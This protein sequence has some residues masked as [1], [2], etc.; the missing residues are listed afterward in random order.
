MFSTQSALKN[1][2]AAK[3]NFKDFRFDIMIENMPIAVM[4]CNI[5]TFEIEYVNEKSNELLETIKHVIDLDPK[6]IVGTSVDVF[7]RDPS[8]QRKLLSDPK[9]LPHQAQITV[10]GE[11][12]DLDISEIRDGRGN[13]TH[14]MLSWS[15]VTDRV[16]KEKETKRLLQMVDKMPINVMTCDIENDF[17]INYMNQTSVDTLSKIQEHLPVQVSTMMGSSID[18]FHKAPTHQRQLLAD[19]NNLPHTA[20]IRVGPEV[21]NL[22]VS[23]IEGEGGEY[24]GPMLTWSIITENVQMAESVTEV[25]ETMSGTSSSMDESAMKMVDLAGEAENLAASVSAASEEMAASIKEISTRISDASRMSQE[26]ANQAKETDGLVSTLDEAAGKIGNITTVINEIA[27]KTNLLALNATIE[28]ARAGDAGKGFA[29]V[30]AEV[31]DLAKQTGDATTE[32]QQQ[33]GSIQGVTGTVVKAI[34]EIS[35]SINELSQI[36]VQ[37]AGAI[38]EQTAT[39]A[40][41]SRNITGVS[42]ASRQTGEAAQGV[43]EVATQL[44]ECSGKLNREISDYLDNT[45]S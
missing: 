45:G 43:R 36:S 31:K 13:Y 34:R 23:K 37:V 18:I 41:V 3:T 1:S 12:L 10:G 35:E 11:Y 26:A 5:K 17:K 19:P 7:H 38:E 33:I 4:V 27:E 14:A 15:V 20:N 9:N 24:L 28:A 16:M 22:R 42:D 6:K 40:E 39:T 30:A 25:V 8:H 32:I 29:V 21:L 2:H 44:N